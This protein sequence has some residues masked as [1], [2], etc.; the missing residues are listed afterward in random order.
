MEKITYG[1]PRL[2]DWVAQIKA[3]GAT[4]RIHF[5]GGALTQ[6]GVTPAEYTTENPF[7]QKV[8]ENS[9]FFKE[10]RIIVVRRTEIREKPKPGNSNPVRSLG[11]VK[12]E[13]SGEN[14]PS[15]EDPASPEDEP[16]AEDS[17]MAED[18]LAEVEVNCL[19]DAQNYLRDHFGIATSRSRSKEKAQALGRENGVMFKGL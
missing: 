1:T 5:T 4:V 10:G 11:T 12:E 13:A 16:P 14:V 19:T 6:Y 15:G 7:M 18:N 8:I 3:G 9:S 17:V 2:V